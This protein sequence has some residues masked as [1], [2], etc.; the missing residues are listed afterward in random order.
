MVPHSIPGRA[1]YT[2]CSIDSALGAPWTGFLGSWLPSDLGRASRHYSSRASTIASLMTFPAISAWAATVGLSEA[3]RW[4][5]EQGR[6]TLDA[7]SLADRSHQPPEHLADRVR[8]VTAVVGRTARQGPGLDTSRLRQAFVDLGY[9][10]MRP[11]TSSRSSK[12]PTGSSE[13]LARPGSALG[14]RTPSRPDGRPRQAGGRS[15]LPV[16]HQTS[17]QRPLAP[18]TVEGVAA[19]DDDAYANSSKRPRAARAKTWDDMAARCGR[20]LSP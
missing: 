10:D 2:T 11:I 3:A 15:D 6:Y 7:I 5:A 17:G 12:G 16:L 18:P 19:L 4:L 20:P 14:S 13:P 1:Q 9:N 8:T